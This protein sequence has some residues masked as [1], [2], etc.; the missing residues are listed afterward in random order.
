MWR[1]KGHAEATIGHSIEETVTG[2]DKEKVNPKGPAADAGNAA[3]EDFSSGL[4]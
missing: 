1:E 3:A 4:H 2:S